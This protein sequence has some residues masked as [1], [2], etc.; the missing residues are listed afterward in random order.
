[1]S[2]VTGNPE[3][4]QCFM[5]LHVAGA[6]AQTVFQTLKIPSTDQEIIALLV[7]AFRIY[8]EGKSN[9]TVVRCKFNSYNQTMESAFVS[10]PIREVIL[11]GL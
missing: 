10:T 4:I 9:I 7:T 11:F 1:M 6:E 3:T 2:D 8:C 5:F